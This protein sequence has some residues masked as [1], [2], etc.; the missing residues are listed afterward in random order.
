MAALGGRSVA[1][2]QVSVSQL[3]ALESRAD[4]LLAR[5]R[6]QPEL[7]PQRTGAYLDLA[8]TAAKQLAVLSDASSVEALV[9][10]FRVGVALQL[11]DDEARAEA[12]LQDCRSHPALSHPQATW[13]GQAIRSYLTGGAQPA[14]GTA[15]LFNMD[16]DAAR[17]YA[18][19]GSM[20]IVETHSSKGSIRRIRTVKPRPEEPHSAAERTALL[21][22]GLRASSPA[23]AEAEG[24]RLLR[25]A[26]FSVLDSVRGD[27]LVVVGPGEGGSA[28]QLVRALTGV[29]DR[30]WRKMLAGRGQPPMLVVYA[31]LQTDSAEEE[32]GARLSQAVHFR[33]SANL[34]GY[35]SRL[36]RSLV[37]RKGLMMD[38]GHQM[39][40]GTAAHE[41]THALLSADY[42]G[43]PYWLDEGMAALVEESD[44]DG[45]PHDNYR[46]Y[47]LLLELQAGRPLSISRMITEGQA[48]EQRLRDA[49]SRYSMMY[50]YSLAPDGA[51]LRRTYAALRD[52]QRAKR[53]GLSHAELLGAWL[54]AARSADAAALDAKFVAF[55]KG[56]DVRGLDERWGQ[57]KPVQL[58]PSL[59]ASP[60]SGGGHELG[61][62]PV[63][64]F[65]MQIR[66]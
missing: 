38:D 31:N 29:R 12:I 40:L 39:M 18:H 28:A 24:L 47:E 48:S 60:R 46:L 16:T 4:Q 65:P 7:H 66:K 49:L 11:A 52:A 5:E 30:L 32:V 9:L 14:S 57:I 25:V 63:D 13:R 58:G 61:Q 21:L 59:A 56:R 20:V 50:L 43:A 44:P 19:D 26:G 1:E 35:F 10:K 15:V 42:P 64:V 22:R 54:S 17:T 55:V 51:V 23:E 45:H 34:E 2:A 27:G 36:D 62:R 37:L 8:V 53:S 6:Q 33:P 3:A 41:L